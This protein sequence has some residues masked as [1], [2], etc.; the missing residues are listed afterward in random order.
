MD[1]F[2]LALAMGPLAVYLLI[3]G[4]VN[5]R[6]R[7]LVTTGTRDTALLAFAVFGLVLVGPMELFLPPAAQFRFG[8]YV[9]P[10]LAAFYGLCVTLW[11]LLA[12]PRLVVYNISIGQLRP[13]LADL[14]ATLDDKARWA[15]DGLVLPQ[16][17]VQLYLECFSPMRNVTLRSSG[18]DQS[19]SGWRRLDA[20]LGEALSQVQVQRNPRGYSFL[21][22]GV[23]MLGVIMWR[24]GT[25]PDL[26]NQALRQMLPGWKL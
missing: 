4:Y 18:P 2:R 17:G 23:L 19:I 8:G 22:M 13:V 24:V 15:G 16:L 1:P 7:P 12:R 26:V 5:L 6:A 21:S 14:V 9:W 25:H 3:L 10:M 20:A 11:I